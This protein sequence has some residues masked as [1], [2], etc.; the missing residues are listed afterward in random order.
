[1]TNIA[2]QESSKLCSRGF[3]NFRACPWTLGQHKGFLDDFRDSGVSDDFLVADFSIF[4]G[5]STFAAKVG[6]NSG[7]PGLAAEGPSRPTMT[8]SDVFF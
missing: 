2:Q 1:M 7:H 8:L 4:H 5:I 6:V 3:P